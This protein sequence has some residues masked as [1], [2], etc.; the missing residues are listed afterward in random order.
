MGVA[1]L[2]KASPVLITGCNGF[3][4]RLLA[5]YLISTGRQVRGTVRRM[6]SAELLPGANAHVVPDIGPDTDWKPALEG[7]EIVI[8]LAALVHHRKGRA[9]ARDSEYFRVNAE[10]TARLAKSS[11]ESGVKRMIFLSTVKVNGEGDNHPYT[12][13]DPE[14]PCGPYAESKLAAERALTEISGATDL[15]SVILRAPLVYGPGVGA[16]FLKLIRLV[17]RQVP[18]PLASVTNRRSLLFIGNLLEVIALVMQHPSAAGQIFLVADNEHLST[19]RLISEIARQIGVSS[20][21]FPCPPLI[22]RWAAALTGRA[23]Q[24]Q[25]LISSL[26]LDT[27]KIRA[28]L[29]WQP[30]YRFEAGIAA[31]LADYQKD[32]AAAPGK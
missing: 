8:H 31:T 29:K 23:P 14:N 6:K 16:T 5:E 3:I 20:R 10:G 21:I 7:I 9:V 11:A 27:T 2:L 13:S 1:V 28:T 15:E 26:Y 17:E 30:P 32:M 24:M 19:P 12:E 4:G 25:R 18:L 22:L